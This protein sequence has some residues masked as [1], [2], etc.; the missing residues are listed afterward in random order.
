MSNKV[1]SASCEH[2]VCDSRRTF[3]KIGLGATALSTMGA[4]GLLVPGVSSAAALTQAQRDQMTAD[5]IIAHMKEGN[6]RFRAGKSQNHDFLA[7]KQA[8]A[9]GQFPA[10]VILS[11]IDSRAPA[12][13]IFDAAIGDSFN[14]RIAGNIA[15][16]DLIGSLEFACA[17]AG[18]KVV[19]V[20]GHTACGAVQGAING[21]ELGSLTGLLKKIKPAVDA[22]QYSGKR[23]G[24]NMEFVDA[25]AKTNVTN[26]IQEI[27]QGSKILADLESKGKIKMVGAIYHLNG[28]LV[29]FLS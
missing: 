6:A 7:Q 20:L 29:E 23:S 1:M 19:L 9:S 24:D 14:A 4:V 2:E 25:V 10:A 17:A 15:N 28:G 16:E 18:A 3:F 12:E 26:T 21:V 22:T 11:C 13:I 27:R 8:S 5:Q